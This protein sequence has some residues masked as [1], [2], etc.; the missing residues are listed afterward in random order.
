[1]KTPSK[2]ILI[3]SFFILTIAQAANKPKKK[4]M[5]IDKLAVFIEMRTVDQ[6]IMSANP[7]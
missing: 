7:L 1:M 6:S 2:N 3:G 5:K 4:V